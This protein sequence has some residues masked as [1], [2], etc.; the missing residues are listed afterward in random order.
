MS[1]TVTLNVIR[2]VLVMMGVLSSTPPSGNWIFV[3][4]FG[5]DAGVWAGAGCTVSNS[6]F[7]G[8]GDGFAGADFS[9]GFFCAVEG[10]IPTSA[11]ATIA[12]KIS[13]G[14]AACRG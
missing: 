1:V 9:E 13:T 4:D 12:H 14:N 3:A 11:A 6:L 10:S 5:S 7:S 2:S 8:E